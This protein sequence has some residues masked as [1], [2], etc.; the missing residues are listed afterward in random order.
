MR[1]LRRIGEAAQASLIFAVLLLPS[2]GSVLAQEGGSTVSVS[3]ITLSGDTVGIGDLVD[4]SF[5]V[6][7]APGTIM[8]MPDSLDSSDFESFEPVRWI[9]EPGPGET[10]RLT[11]T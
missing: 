2:P 9:S 7:M 6:D 11:V 10:V 8:F 3:E 4:L 1:E 5:V